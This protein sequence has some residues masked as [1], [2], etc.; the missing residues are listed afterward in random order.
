MAGVKNLKARRVKNKRWQRTPKKMKIKID[1][2]KC[3][4]CGACE[5]VCPSIFAMKDGKAVAKTKQTDEKCAEEAA[6]SCPVQAIEL[7]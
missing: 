1:V 2:E 6:D 3:I 7:R 5:A 4:G